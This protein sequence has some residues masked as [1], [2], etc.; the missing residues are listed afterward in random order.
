MND[1]AQLIAE[2]DRLAA[3]LKAANDKLAALLASPEYTAAYMLGV[4]RGR[5]ECA[6][7]CATMREAILEVLRIGVTPR[8]T[9]LLSATITPNAGVVLLKRMAWLESVATAARAYYEA[10]DE[11]YTL[12]HPDNLWPGHAREVSDRYCAAR[13]AL[14]AAIAA[15]P[16]GAAKGLA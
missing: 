6:A 13:D 3:E 4:E 12:G 11:Y 14:L 15:E 16:K 9:N 2:R 5:D 8:Q 10:A 7:Q 1:V